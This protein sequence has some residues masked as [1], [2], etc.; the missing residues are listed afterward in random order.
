MG[1]HVLNSLV[2]PA[3]EIH[4]NIRVNKKSPLHEDRLLS[5]SSLRAVT[6]GRSSLSFHIP[7]TFPTTFSR[8]VWLTLQ[9]YMS[10]AS[11]ISSLCFLPLSADRALSAARSSSVRYIWVLLMRLLTMYTPA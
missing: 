4:Q 1:F 11:R 7:A 10:T 6:S 8:L 3:Q 9:M 2:V 5:H